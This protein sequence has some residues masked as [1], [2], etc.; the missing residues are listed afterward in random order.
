MAEI[1]TDWANKH[2]YTGNRKGQNKELNSKLP[3][4]L[5]KGKSLCLEKI[6]A[7]YKTWLQTSSDYKFKGLHDFGRASLSEAR[8]SVP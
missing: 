1:S 2:V 8:M 3:W 4:D 7:L 5:L 6:N